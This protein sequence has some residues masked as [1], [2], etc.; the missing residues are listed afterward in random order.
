LII[1]KGVLKGSSIDRKEVKAK[2]SEEENR[3]GVMKR[4]GPT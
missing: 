1:G 2:K 3:E 4:K